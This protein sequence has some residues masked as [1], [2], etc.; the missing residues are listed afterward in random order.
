MLRL[1][2]VGVLLAGC[3]VPLHAQAP[4]DAR[5]TAVTF[6][7]P[8]AVDAHTTHEPAIAV[9][10][11]GS[12][13]MLAPEWFPGGARLWKS[14]DAGAT[15]VPIVFGAVQSNPGDASL[16]IAPDGSIYVTELTFG[17]TLA[18]ASHDAGAT[19]SPPALA[20]PFGSPDREWTAVD[21]DGR[22]YLVATDVPADSGGWVARSDDGGRT[23]TPLGPAWNR[24]AWGRGVNGPLVVNPRTGALHLVHLCHDYTAVCASTSMDHAASWMTHLVADRGTWTFNVV[25]SLAADAAGNLYAAWSDAR[26]GSMDV[27]M[28][29]S[30]DA[31]AWSA[32]VRVNARAGTHVMPWIAAAG[33]GHVAIAWYATDRVGDNNDVAAMRGASWRVAFAQ[34]FDGLSER[35]A[36]AQV[37]ATATIHVGSLSTAA[38]SAASNPPDRGLGDLLTLALDRDG[39]AL[40]AFCAGGSEDA[41]AVQPMFIRQAS[42][43]ML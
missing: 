11:D 34:T 43:P 9:A 7:A 28:S 8:I 14:L 1:V 37:N 17:G 33:A 36:F 35:P 30:R 40:I 4:A 27:W 2:I 20:G 16:S 29:A 26:S 22:V 39:R 21:A 6:S 18:W 15:W 5:P 19:W 10:P 24:V 12:I 42:G 31:A 41:K 23:W 13:W 3:L 32:P 38:S 25:P